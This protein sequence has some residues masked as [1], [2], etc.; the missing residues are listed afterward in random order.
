MSY[1]YVIAET[2]TYNDSSEDIKFVFPSR[3]FT[4]EDFERAKNS[5]EEKVKAANK[6]I[7]AFIQY[8]GKIERPKYEELFSEYQ[9]LQQSVRTSSL[10]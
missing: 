2:L 6:A 10:N 8:A 5:S 3:I 4:P 9:D 1:K 7:K